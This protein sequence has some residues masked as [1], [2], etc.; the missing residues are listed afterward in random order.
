MTPVQKRFFVI[1]F[2][3]LALGLFG[4][5]P[6]LKKE[7]RK[8]EE[9]LRPVRFFYPAFHD[10][11]DF[12]S[13][14]SAVRRNLEYLKRLD[15][16][17]LFR[18][19]P[20]KFTCR[21]VLDS[22]QAFLKLLLL[23]PDPARLDREIR[24]HFLIY[25]AAGRAGNHHVLFTGYFEPTFDASLTRDGTFE[26]PLYK[27]PDDLVRIDLSR[28]REKFEGE[29]IVARIEGKK[30]L[31]Y[32]TREEID[33]GKV[34]A[35][36][37]LELAWLKDPVDVAF[38]Q[39]QGSGVLRLRDGKELC[40]GYRASNGWTYRSIGRYMLDRGLMTQE[41]MS[42]QSIRKYLSEHPQEKDRILNQ[43]PS[44]VFFQIQNN[45]PLGNI[46]VPLT[47][48]RSLALDAS[49]FPKG[50][51][52]FISCRKPV[53]NDRGEITDWTPFSR[54]VLNQD[55]GGAI[56]GAGRADL[57]WGSGPYA[58]EAAGHLKEEGDLYLLIKR[59]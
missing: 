8:P 45:G 20:R 32:Y 59:P 25:R 23:A 55:T 31:P 40:V 18:Y 36:R 44:Y 38:L 15:P 42:M 12:D 17:Y 5:Y 48:G 33:S 51:L 53:L 19:G 58:E 9:A 10:D 2:L 54:F 11:Q 56:K 57:F 16:E 43:N 49:L 52:A 14:I 29:S 3:I 4:C 34:L 41:Q 30:V 37:D 26:Y 35:G 6:A 13:L 24:K 1:I 21:Q 46:N 28:F 47:P 50:A 27:Q 22:Q 7:A 39:I